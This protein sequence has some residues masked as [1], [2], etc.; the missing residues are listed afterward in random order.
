MG[1]VEVG[2]MAL[3]SAEMFANEESSLFD[4]ICCKLRVLGCR[5]WDEGKLG[6]EW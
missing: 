6:I 3:S 5:Q 1:V 2:W 4:E